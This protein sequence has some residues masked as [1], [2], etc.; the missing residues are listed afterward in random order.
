MIVS[1]NTTT[2]AIHFLPILCY[3]LN[4]SAYFNDHYL[5]AT[6]KRYVMH[7]M[8]LRSFQPSS[9][10]FFTRTHVHIAMFC[11]GR[12]YKKLAAQNELG[13]VPA[14]TAVNT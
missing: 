12:A 9:E 2:V 4:Q 7:V 8:L 6:Q 13:N 11:F 3:L 1:G 5:V 10:L 14:E